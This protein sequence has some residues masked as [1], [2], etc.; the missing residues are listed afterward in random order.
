MK[1]KALALFLVIL[2]LAIPAMQPLS[3]TGTVYAY[4]DDPFIDGEETPSPEPIPD[5]QTYEI[6]MITA[7]NPYPYSDPTDPGTHYI[8]VDIGTPEHEIP[9]PGTLQATAEGGEKDACIVDVT[10]WMCIG[11]VD[12]FSQYS[13]DENGFNK[14]AAGIYRFIPNLALEDNETLSEALSVQINMLPT[15]YTTLNPPLI[16]VDVTVNADAGGIENGEI[17]LMASGDVCEIVGGM[18]Y[19]S[20]AD[21]IAAV[22]NYNSTPANARTIKLLQ[23]IDH[24]A[25]LRI[26]NKHIT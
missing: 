25:G 21:A 19:V 1:I 4:A 18:R 13:P 8:T 10:G 16:F 24:K 26:D 2:T 17:M 12:M 23:D 6:V 15:Q 11:M 20:I 7:F 3:G 9:L 14:D 5:M 22:P